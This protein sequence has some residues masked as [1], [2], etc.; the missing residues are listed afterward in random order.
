M[1]CVL[2]L[3]AAAA[4]VGAAHAQ[5]PQTDGVDGRRALAP[6]APAAARPNRLSDLV[7]A[8]KRRDAPQPHGSGSHAALTAVVRAALDEALALPLPSS[9]GVGSGARGGGPPA[10]ATATGQW[11]DAT[12]DF[13][14]LSGD[15]GDRVE[16]TIGGVTYP[17]L[18][19][20]EALGVLTSARGVPLSGLLVDGVLVLDPLHVPARCYAAAGHC[21]VGSAVHAN[22]TAA[23]AGQI[24]GEAFFR[25]MVDQ[26]DAHRPSR[27][28]HSLD[29]SDLR[30]P[31]P[32]EWAAAA[33]A[34][35][36][37][38][39]S[40][41]GGGGPLQATGVSDAVD[42][43]HR[44]RSLYIQ[45][46][47][48][49]GARSYLILRL[50]W[51]NM[52]LP[53]SSLVTEA[54]ALS[55]CADFR[56]Y[57][58]NQ[59]YGALNA[60]VTCMAACVYNTSSVTEANATLASN[61]VIAFE[62]MASVRAAGG[63]CAVASPDAYSHVVILHPQGAF[64]YAG[65]AQT[66]GK[67]IWANGAS[68]VA[69]WCVGSH[70]AAHAL[71]ARHSYA[72]NPGAAPASS[73]VWEYGS[74]TDVMGGTKAVW[75]G[76]AF[77]S[78]IKDQLGWLPPGTL[79]DVAAAVP[80]PAAAAPA[81]T[82][83]TTVTLAGIERADGAAVA[84]A[85]GAALSVRFPATTGALRHYAYL[86]HRP[87]YSTAAASAGGTLAGVVIDELASDYGL[88]SATGGSASIV[89][90]PTYYATT[91]GQPLA[92]DSAPSSADQLDA[93]IGPGDAYVYGAPGGPAAW[94]FVSPAVTPLLIEVDANTSALPPASAA[95]GDRAVSARLS[96]LDRA[97]L[98]RAEG[99]GCT[100]HGG[101][102]PPL[103]SAPNVTCGTRVALV[104]EAA[105][106]RVGVF[107]LPA[108]PA[109]AASQ[110]V[111]VTSCGGNA[112]VAPQ[113]VVGVYTAPPAAQA[114]YG[115]SFGRGALEWSDVT[116]SGG[117]GATP[118]TAAACGTVQVALTSAAPLYVAVGV[119]PAT[120]DAAPYGRPLVSLGVACAPV[121]PLVRRHVLVASGSAAARGA[122]F[123]LPGTTGAV[124]N[125]RLR[126]HRH[127]LGQ[128]YDLHLAYSP[129]YGGWGVWVQLPHSR[130]WAA[131]LSSAF[132]TFSQGFGGYDPTVLT[133]STGGTSFSA[134]FAC[135]AGTF[136][137][138]TTACAA[139]PAP[140]MW[141]PV[142]STASSACV[143][144]PGAGLVGGVCTPC[145]ANSFKS[146][147]GN[148]SCT[149]CPA[150]YTTGGAVGTSSFWACT[151]SVPFCEQYTVSGLAVATFYNGVF[152][153]TAYQAFG[154]PVYRRASDGLFL[155][156]AWSVNRWALMTAGSDPPA[157]SY[158]FYTFYSMPS[159]ALPQTWAPG[160]WG[161]L[162]PG[163]VPAVSCTCASGATPSATTG[164]C[165]TPTPSSA[166]A[167]GT[168]GDGTTCALCPPFQV[169]D[170]TGTGCV[171]PD[172]YL[173]VGDSCSPPAL[174]AATVTACTGSGCGDFAA[175]VAGT[176]WE[177]VPP[178]RNVTLP[179][180]GSGGNATVLTPVYAS[181][182]ASSPLYAFF[183]PVRSE[184]VVSAEAPAVGG[185]PES[186]SSVSLPAR[187]AYRLPPGGNATV[188][189]LGSA[190]AWTV[191]SANTTAFTSVAVVSFA[192]A[193]PSVTPS[194]TGSAS[195]TPPPTASASRTASG[196]LTATPS[197]SSPPT[198]SQ[199]PSQ[200]PSQTTTATGTATRSLSASTTPSGTTSQT[201]TATLSTSRSGTGTPP[202]TPS[203]SPTASTTAAAT[204]TGT[205]SQTQTPTLSSSLSG[206]GTPPPTQSSTSTASGTAAATTTS[207]PTQTPTPTPSTSLSGSGTP[208]P[209]P[210]SSAT[211]SW[212]AAETTSGT[213]SLTPTSTPSPSQSGTATPPSTPSASATSSRTAAETTSTT[214]SQTQTPTPSSSLSETG[215][216]T[217]TLSSSSSAS[218][219]AAA[220]T[221]R[222]PTGTLTSSGTAAA[223]SSPSGTVTGTSTASA[224][225]T[226]SPA[227][228]LTP[229]ATPSPTQTGSPSGSQSP[230]VSTTAA[231]TQSLTATPSQS[232]T[233]TPSRT[234]T[235]TQSSAPTATASVTASGTPTRTQ[236]GTPSGTAAS[237]GTATATS[238]LSGSATATASLTRSLGAT[239][240]SSPSAAATTSPSATVTAS[241]TPAP[242]GTGSATATATP[243]L[244]SSPTAPVTGSPTGT[245]SSP[246]TATSSGTA[247]P[248]ATGSATGTP[249][250]TGSATGTTSPPPTASGTTS[251][252][253]STSPTSASTTS[254]TATRSASGSASTTPTA[255]STTSATGS[256]S[257]A[258][259][260][261]PTGSS[262]GSSTGSVSA[263][264]SASLSSTASSSGTG[265]GTGSQTPP[266][267]A[268]ATS[269]GTQSQSESPAV[270]PSASAPPSA[271]GTPSR[272]RT[273]T[274]SPTKSR[275]PTTS[276]TRTGSRSRTPSPTPT[277]T[278][279]ASKRSRTRTPSRTRTR[280][281]TRSRT[282]KPK[283]LA[284]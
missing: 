52:T 283:R 74:V 32:P 150:S 282:K 112:S 65:L 219:T 142:G 61:N 177:L 49:A 84:A 166:C 59:S 63:A 250:V 98:E 29:G 40:S 136:A 43:G 125:S 6:D 181:R 60:S 185:A 244:S 279:T 83:S 141:S 249:S 103:A 24:A 167:P 70:E 100:P 89:D 227:P 135:P 271:T 48:S 123:L 17:A 195:S 47:V 163:D 208:P 53:S 88:F 218:A 162:F 245:A 257:A 128:F 19:S 2:S 11:I 13:D 223:T 209:T 225:P 71:G 248:P 148:A 258:P 31:R 174:V 75:P 55:V 115:A 239:P 229:T 149:A 228:T 132:L 45:A 221:S 270:T 9:P 274:P 114:L 42:G 145:A 87:A 27:G 190:D 284:Q 118:A 259:T 210:S 212:T 207:T 254:A 202:P 151:P 178:G 7:A 277:G 30:A 129:S 160:D 200:T 46:G 28:T 82:A 182:N 263:T 117:F 220:T 255:A 157:G 236:S 66:P 56:T 206:T 180:G 231:A 104:L 232:G 159:A 176:V 172:G 276:R 81:T 133:L 25:G 140:Y 109:G 204:A 253:A 68:G 155:A 251:G 69:L 143:C 57:L 278:R 126:F 216:P 242:T 214:P 106:Q 72:A 107:R 147:A 54:D 247:T 15:A 35:A 99:R 33:A 121:A 116:T 138:N 51:V 252:S 171:C 102:Q 179:S 153:R 26:L 269:T 111:T 37:R 203:L 20:G 4:C 1:R 243:S 76:L 241:R 94:S 130:D 235:S 154:K 168:A 80:T 105:S 226:S 158:S 21:R 199:T 146:A 122:Y 230:T 246:A 194:G 201:P 50:A 205:P 58:N 41:G 85:Y 39:R 62:A 108:L 120:W 193:S 238:T 101:C 73:S 189:S 5:A 79:V 222:T 96:W 36:A 152:D 265:S 22:V 14:L 77:T 3:L 213:P 18:T 240:S 256:G 197:P 137:V 91:T 131:T 67:Y 38:G 86:T 92:H 16:V 280:T 262:S 267:T 173:L 272:S 187:A 113:S 224:A 165:P 186:A 266:G 97:S 44:G 211:A 188:F 268:A 139:C 192:S 23:R 169:A 275:L 281:A 175:A 12:G 233:P 93:A 8:A 196:T 64:S 164:A 260:T 144:A 264:S 95:A 184:W 34:A 134:A 90:A 156:W 237:T 215:T 161:G 124:Y 217:P 198:S 234:G 170:A 110:V 78:G 273:G 119:P 191:W 183:T 261:S 10:Q 127:Y